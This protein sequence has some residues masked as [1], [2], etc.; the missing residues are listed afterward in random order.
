MNRWVGR[1]VLLLA[2]GSSSVVQAQMTTECAVSLQQ[3]QALRTGMSYRQVVSTLGCDGVELSRS[4]LGGI[5]TAM[6]A[7]P[8]TGMHGA[9]M[10]VM[11]QNDRL[12]SKAQLGLAR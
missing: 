12:I 5:I 6:Y 10:N 9:N 1:A 4:E 8:G 3:F 7:W 11:L 2:L